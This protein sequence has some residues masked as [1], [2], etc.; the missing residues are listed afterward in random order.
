MSLPEIS[1]RC[2]SCGASVR[3]GA[4]FCPQCGAEMSLD[5]PA[6][7]A[8]S[9]TGVSEQPPEKEL[10]VEGATAVGE[11]DFLLEED[12][13][14]F[15]ERDISHIG[16]TGDQAMTTTTKDAAASLTESDGEAAVTPPRAAATTMDGGTGA[17]VGRA[18]ASVRDSVGVVV[19]PRVERVRA[20]SSVVL[21]E[22]SE[23]SGL[24][25][26]IIA[27]LLFLVFLLFLLLSA[28]LK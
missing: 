28:V 22:A 9:G 18:A 1:Q 4:R 7:I 13:K 10:N 2:L 12:W 11:D 27:V 8:Q 26:V 14:K 3:A 20:A 19:R 25:F 16:K 23:D 15:E 24:R 17:K 5:E 6:A 21:E